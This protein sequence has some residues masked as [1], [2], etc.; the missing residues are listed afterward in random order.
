[1]ATLW[2]R[3]LMISF[4]YITQLPR[5]D[6]VPSNFDQTCPY[7]W[8]FKKQVMVTS[9]FFRVHRLEKKKKSLLEIW[10][11]CTCGAITADQSEFF[12]LNFL[13]ICKSYLHD[14]HHSTEIKLFRSSFDNKLVLVV[15]VIFHKSNRQ[16]F[17]TKLIWNT[18]DL[19]TVQN[20]SF[21][22]HKSSIFSYDVFEPFITRNHL[23]N[24]KRVQKIS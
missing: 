4:Y 8:T 11:R 12:K 20:R 24:K 10:S 19:K 13:K 14:F 21:S 16:N 5:L 3:S 22:D 15:N 7:S 18:S 1:M 2:W 17:I 6:G 23:V 9:S